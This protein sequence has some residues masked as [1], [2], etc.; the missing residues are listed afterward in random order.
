MADVTEIVPQIQQGDPSAA[1]QL[2]PVVYDELRKLAA[3]PCPPVLDRTIAKIPARTASGSSAHRSTTRARSGSFGAEPAPTAPH[4][5]PRASGIDVFP[6]FREG[7]SSPSRTTWGSP[8]ST[9]TRGICA[10]IGS[11]S[12]PK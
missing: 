1:D 12:P 4:S 2:L 11:C 6:S 10:A 7:G 5:A 9:R 3:V 8:A